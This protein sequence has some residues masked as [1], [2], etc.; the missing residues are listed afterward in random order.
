MSLK[1]KINQ[2][3]VKLL[4]ENVVEI[5]N[6]SKIKLFR[7][8]PTVEIFMKGADSI[9][10]SLID[11]GKTNIECKWSSNPRKGEVYLFADKPLLLD[12]NLIKTLANDQA[13]RIIDEF[14]GESAYRLNI[15]RVTKLVKN[16]FYSVAVV[17]LVSAF[18]NAMRDIFFQN[19]GF[20]FYRSNLEIYNIED[21]Y[22]KKYG[23]KIKEL[24]VKNSFRLGYDKDIDGE[25]WI[26]TTTDYNKCLD[27][28]RIQYWD[29]IYSIC[30]KIPKVSLRPF[31]SEMLL[32]FKSKVCNFIF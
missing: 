11:D 9:G 1:E 13:K 28:K 20:W 6:D 2:E 10:M 31:K 14:Q 27:W 18:E 4:V 15:E 24:K 17:F 29:K 26:L 22:V 19:N 32:S 5:L 21:Y 30:K 7:N 16:K 25:K 12:T 23:I 3:N 8:N